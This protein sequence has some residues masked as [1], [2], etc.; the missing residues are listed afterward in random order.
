MY[1]LRN[2]GKLY[3][4]L[5]LLPQ[6][7]DVILLRP[8]NANQNEQLTRQFRQQF[9]V[10]R[11]VI[12]QWLDYLIQHHQG[13][14]HITIDQQSLSQLPED[15]EI[16]RVFAVD[17]LDDEVID[18]EADNEADSGDMETGAVSNTLAQDEKLETLHQQVHGR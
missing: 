17:E 1:F 12:Q 5:P 9:R 3:S 2:V 16:S 14:R 15:S 18:N 11:G 7:L 4:Q 10:R 8:K 13:Y 6:D